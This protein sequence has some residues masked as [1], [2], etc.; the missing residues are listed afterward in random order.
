MNLHDEIPPIIA[1][2]EVKQEFSQMNA[3]QLHLA[4]KKADKNRSSNLLQMAEIWTL[5]DDAQMYGQLGYNS[6]AEYIK[7][8]FN[9]SKSTAIAIMRVHRTFV[10]ELGCGK[11]Q[12][13]EIGYPNLSIVAA[14]TTEE[15]LEEVLELCTHGKQPEIREWVKAQNPEDE[16]VGETYT[17]KV[18]GPVDT[19]GT[20]KTAVDIAREEYAES[21]DELDPSSVSNFNSLE[22]LA[23]NYLTTR[24]LDGNCKQSI[25]ENLQRF[26]KAYNLKPIQ[27][28]FQPDAPNNE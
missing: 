14:H 10:E 25:D 15:N 2:A 16:D 18:S 12:I 7:E 8:E 28:E 20:I 22:L 5:I 9:R 26:A 4:A 11:E 23:A 17:L 1:T 24:A 6:F 13:E 3:E 21:Y 27:W 19:L